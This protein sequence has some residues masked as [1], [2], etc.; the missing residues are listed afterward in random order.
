[1]TT[2]YYSGAEIPGW[3]RL[4]AENGVGH[5]AFSYMGLR[6]RTKF[7]KPWL[8]REKVKEPVSLLLDSGAHTVNA[9]P[10]LYSPKMLMEHYE[11]FVAANI[12]DVEAVLDFDVLS[13]G[14]EAR[15]EHLRRLHEVA[16]EKL[17]PVWHAQDG[18]EELAALALAFPT[19]AVAEVKAGDDVLRQIK[20][21]A[22]TG[23]GF[24]GLAL[25]KPDLIRSLPLVGVTGTSWLSPIQHGETV[26]YT[27]RELHRFH[28]K[29]QDT[30]RTRYRTQIEAMGIDPQAVADGESGA[31]LSLSLR[32]WEA[33]VRDVVTRSPS[34]PS[35]RNGDPGMDGPDGRPTETR[36]ETR[37]KI[38][39]PGLAYTDVVADDG[40]STERQVQLV[41]TTLRECNSCYIRA[42][43]RAF[44]VDA[45]CAFE[46]PELTTPQIRSLR[47]RMQTAR[48]MFAR[49]AEEH[50][51][52]FPNPVVSA[53]LDRLDRMLLTDR[54]LESEELTLH[55]RA[56]RTGEP[57]MGA[58]IISQI[59]GRETAE[60]HAIAPVRSDPLVS[61][62]LDAEVVEE[63]QE[64]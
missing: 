13:L 60:T 39:M 6:R 47:L 12:A 2:I 26:I 64:R 22:Q 45:D 15:R 63:P 17:V 41:D 59:F 40:T 38:P 1:M 16:G 30:V 42:D 9:R 3:R 24:I 32:S 56:S 8:I 36:H 34:T 43:C 27:G 49:Q 28:A 62:I 50:E 53:E 18:T 31:L 58:G 48:V 19:V 23:T 4:M 54:K 37:P 14:I 5:A 20:T 57:T 35:E 29:Y 21:L 10:D 52:G 44:Q 25:L 33:F 61:Q 7:V 55:L 51:G 46:V 11:R